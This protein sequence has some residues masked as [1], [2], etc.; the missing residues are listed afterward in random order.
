L[1]GAHS[2]GEEVEETQ[3]RGIVRDAESIFC[4]N[5][6]HEQLVQVT[7]VTARLVSRDAK[8]LLQ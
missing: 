5:V 3:I 6:D 2:D 1:Q 4:G 7:P 8:E